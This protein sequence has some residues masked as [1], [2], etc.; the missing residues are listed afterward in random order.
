MAILK[1]VASSLLNVVNPF[2]YVNLAVGVPT[3]VLNTIQTI[4]ETAHE[5]KYQT[6]VDAIKNITGT[7][8]DTIGAIATVAAPGYTG[9]LIAGAAS[10]IGTTI[11]D[12]AEAVASPASVPEAVNAAA[13]AIIQGSIIPIASAVLPVPIS[14]AV[15]S[16]AAVVNAS[17]SGISTLVSAFLGS[18]PQQLAA[19]DGQSA[20]LAGRAGADVIAGGDRGDLLLGEGGAD[21]IDGGDGDDI[22]LAGSGNDDISGDA[23]NDKL[24]GGADDDSLYGEAGSDDLQG[25]AGSDKLY[26]GDG[27][28]LLD[29]GEGADF[30]NGGAGNDVYYVSGA[31]TLY[32]EGG[33]NDI[34]VFQNQGAIESVVRSGD[35]LD[36][37]FSSAGKVS[38]VDYFAGADH[39]V[40]YFAFDD[41]D[42]IAAADLLAGYDLAG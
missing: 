13:T 2:Y 33:D 4:T 22:I 21:V 26:G 8:T 14:T 11:G 32:E 7:V 9:N 5:V 30:L 16:I 36:I 35:D 15:N 24:H 3:L 25:D 10:S 39:E 18:N 34:A 20:I 40:D 29:G 28:D 1:A 12:V 23:G 38:I 31:D 6:P 27:D 19:G 42:L 37:F 17:F 41:G